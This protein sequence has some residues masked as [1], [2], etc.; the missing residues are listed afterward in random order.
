MR[1]LCTLVLLSMLALGPFAKDAPNAA[2]DPA[3]EA[4]MMRIAQELRCLVCQNQTIADSHADLAVDRREEV[5]V[6]FRK[7]ESDKQV[8]KYMT[9]RYGEF[10]LYRPPVKASTWLLWFGPGVLLV[11]GLLGLILLLRK[12]TRMSDDR[13]EPDE[14]DGAEGEVRS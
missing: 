13:F 10:V 9:D 14:V 6:M 3:L 2:A 12:R 1:K 11:G 8:L 5:R 4:R 7:G